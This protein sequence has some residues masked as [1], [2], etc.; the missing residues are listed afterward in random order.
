MLVSLNWIRSLISCDAETDEIARKLTD[1]GLTVDAIT[2]HGDDTVLEL[3]I[4]ANRP[5]CLGHLGV[6]REVAAGFGLPAPAPETASPSADCNVG[7]EIDDPVGCPRFTASVVRGIHVS[8]SPR[9]VVDRLEACGLRSV[10][11]VVDASNLVMLETGNPIHFYDLARVQGGLLRVRRA[12]A[13]ERLTTLD[14]IERELTPEMLVI[15]DGGRAVGLAGVMGGGDTEIREDTVDVL[16]EAAFF[17]PPTIRR[18]ARKLG[19]HTD[20]SHRFERGANRDGVL[21]AQHMAR[22][23]LAE[24][25]G[26]KPD[27]ALRDHH[28]E[29]AEPQRL[30]LR[31]ARVATLLGYR[32]EPAEIRHALESVGLAPEETAEGIWTVTVPSWRVDLLREADLVEEV[33]RDLGYERVP[34]M[35]G[36][37]ERLPIGSRQRAADQ[38]E[39]RARDLLAHLG[40]HE[41]VSYAMIGPDEDAPFVHGETPAGIPLSNPLAEPLSSLRRSILPGLLRALDRNQR[42]GTRDVRLFEL[43]HVFHDRSTGLPLEPA[44]LALVWSGAS[45]PT[46]WSAP[47]RDVGLA[48]IAG[49]VESVISGVTRQPAPERHKLEGIDGFHPAVSTA[50]LRP[51]GSRLAWAGELHPSVRDA[52]D[53][54]AGVSMAEIE[55]GKL[56]G[57]RG[58]P[59]Q[60]EP[61]PRF[62]SPARDLSLV[63][64]AGV[65]FADIVEAVEKVP[66]PAPAEV[67]LIDR[68]AGA[69]LEQGQVSL[70]VRLSLHP[71]E[72]TLTDEETESY[73]SGVVQRLE[74]LGGIRLRD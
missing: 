43:G 3:D 17:D 59:S 61:I 60:Y 45:E 30:E 54:P 44:R 58:G 10:N 31:A 27:L 15:A 6:A 33:A 9:W 20:A 68:Y 65:R 62:P 1:R 70:T 34:A 24:L 35:R 46:H 47:V 7:V 53:L 2:T 36:E 48:D 42:R 25:A 11:N 73:R 51:D 55:I 40:F 57:S 26:G 28:P 38:I 71:R 37:P 49:L 14:E 8:P 21:A 13:G 16:I 69:P 52:L 12:E 66:A 5:D 32:P 74:G 18:T 67:A 29:P 56:A 63:L 39:E 64:D 4:P 22:R 50:W 72:R 41:A 23:L 19:L